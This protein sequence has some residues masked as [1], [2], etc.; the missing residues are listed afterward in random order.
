MEKIPPEKCWAITAKSLLAF[1]ILR[2]DKVI[3]PELGRGKD[4][5]SPL[6]AKEKW[7][8]INDK[9]YGKGGRMMY[10]WIKEMFN[11]PVEDAIGAAKLSV[12]VADLAMGPEW[13]WEYVEKSPERVKYRA[14]RCPWW[15]RYQEHEVRWEYQACHAGDLRWCS[16]G[17]KAINPKLTYKITKARPWGDPYCEF[18]IEFKEE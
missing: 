13:E 1:T 5:I 10:P 8:E 14:N 17:L 12:L 15:E 18:V 3:A 2:G 6:L 11:I 7:E 16:S 4:I 9:V